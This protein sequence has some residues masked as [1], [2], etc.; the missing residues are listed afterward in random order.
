MHYIPNLT[1]VYLVVYKNRAASRL[2]SEHFSIITG[3]E[4]YSLND[5]LL[6]DQCQCCES[7]WID[8]WSRRSKLD[9]DRFKYCILSCNSV[10]GILR[11]NKLTKP[12]WL[13][14]KEWIPSENTFFKVISLLVGFLSRRRLSP[15][16]EQRGDFRVWSRLH[17]DDQNNAWLDHVR[18]PPNVDN[19]L[20]IH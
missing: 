16:S 14:R 9:W 12:K 15:W 3:S 17:A 6:Q 19:N 13:S 10:G 1:G 2:Q 8:P 4:C 11:S 20:L 18:S 5:Y 7:W